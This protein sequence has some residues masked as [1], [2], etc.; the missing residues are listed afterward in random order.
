MFAIINNK[1]KQYKVE[2]DSSIKI[3]RTDLKK[4][5]KITFDQVLLIND[6]KSTKVGSPIVSGATVV[7]KV[8]ENKKDDK[9]IVFKKKRRHNYRRK[10]GHRQEYTVVKI[11]EIKVS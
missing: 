5:S 3:D 9:V 2:K 1:G 8:V 4:N 10:I 11:E 6:S 7:G